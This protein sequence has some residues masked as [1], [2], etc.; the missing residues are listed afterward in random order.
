MIYDFLFGNIYLNLKHLSKT[1]TGLLHIQNIHY[2][3]SYADLQFQSIYFN[4][5]DTS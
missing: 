5:I 2:N 1:V 3:N 4:M